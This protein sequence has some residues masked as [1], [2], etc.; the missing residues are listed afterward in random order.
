M[1]PLA[2]LLLLVSPAAPR[3]SV[4]D[5]SPVDRQRDDFYGAISGGKKVTAA[6]ALSTDKAKLGADLTLT[7]TV[8]NAANP[9]E[10]SRPPL[11]DRDDFRKLF[12]VI[13][14]IP[15]P[16]PP[17]DAAKV[18][19]RYKVRPRA[20]GAFR[21]PELKYLYYAQAAPPDRRFQ[22]AFVAAVPFSV[23]K[24]PVPKSPVVPLDGP[25]QFFQ[26]RSAA[27]FPPAGG[28]GPWWWAGLL[29]GAA[30]LAV[31]WIVGW[32]VLNPDA[33][34]LARVRRTRAVRVSLDRLRAAGRSPDPTAATAAAFR[35]YLHDRFGLP[36]SA[37]TPAE[38]AAGLT[39]LN[40]PPDR[41]AEAEQL[42]RA[43]DAA[44]FA[45]VGDAPVSPTGAV[46]LIERWEGVAA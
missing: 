20:E 19:F 27:V 42:L 40:L 2:L 30:V 10:L 43:C 44:R 46:R 7:L 15:G 22:T 6:W 25:P 36:Y 12:G 4:N 26:V 39:G 24:P 5:L 3:P 16:A 23:S 9:H 29:G 34:R 11:A 41:I 37:T 35:R 1:P 13:E 28:P 17:P 14:D 31:G 32:R 8:T 18:E 33:A 45:P 21:V 38:V